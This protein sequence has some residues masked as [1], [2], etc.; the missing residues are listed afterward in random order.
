M[1]IRCEMESWYWSSA[2][3]CVVASIRIPLDRHGITTFQTLRKV[4]MC[5]SY[6]TFKSRE[7]G[8]DIF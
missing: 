1:K 5:W 3:Y 6:I 8:Y 4:L 2:N 7:N